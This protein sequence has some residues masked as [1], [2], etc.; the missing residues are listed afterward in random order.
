[1]NQNDVDTSPPFAV[2]LLSRL[3][4]AQAAITGTGA[5]VAVAA[6]LI[7]RTPQVGMGTIGDLR[8]HPVTVL[9]FATAPIVAIGW[10]LRL[11]PRPLSG[12][13]RAIGIVEAILIAD[14]VLCLAAGVF[15][16]W[17]VTGLL[18]AVTIVWTLRTDTVVSYLPR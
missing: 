12:A 4:L 6:Y 3:L 10:V 17:L 18:L 2:R 9:V 7:R 13:R 14:H 15:N 5:L 16:V 1:M 8:T 11:I